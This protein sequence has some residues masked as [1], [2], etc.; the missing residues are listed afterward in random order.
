MKRII[1]MKC[2]KQVAML[3][4]RTPELIKKKIFSEKFS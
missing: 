3:H 1:E 4:D 2:P